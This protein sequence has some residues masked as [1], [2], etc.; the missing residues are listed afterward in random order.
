MGLAAPQVGVNVRLM[1]FNPE[2]KRG[3]VRVHRPDSIMRRTQALLMQALPS[4]AAHSG[5][6]R[7]R[8]LSSVRLSRI[9][10]LQGG[11][12]LQGGSLFKNQ[13]EELVLAN[14]RIIS[15][16]RNQELGEEGCLS[17]LKLNSDQLIRADVEVP[18]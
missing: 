3:Q 14:P 8:W 7:C 18:S 10:F 2:G 11:S 15:S 16:S 4:G 5:C 13:G 17:F 6:C 1:V 9:F 12:N